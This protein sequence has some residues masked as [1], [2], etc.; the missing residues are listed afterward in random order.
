MLAI[1]RALMGRPKLLLLDEPSLGLSPLLVQ[2]IF[3]HH[4]PH[5]SR[6]RASPSCWSSRTPTSRC[7]PPT[8]AMCWRSGAS[9]LADHCATLMQTR[10]HQGILP[11][12]EGNRASAASGD[13]KGSGC[14]TE[15]HIPALLAERVAAHGSRNDPAQEGPRHLEGHRPGR[16]LAPRVR[17]IG[18]GLTAIGFRSRRRRLRD[19]GDAARNGSYVDLG[20]LGAGGVSGGIHPERG[21]ASRSARR[22]A[23]RDAACCSSRTRSSSTR[24]SG[25]RAAARRCDA[26]VI[27]D[28]KGL[29]DF[30]DPMCE[31]LADRSSHAPPDDRRLGSAIAADRRRISQPCCCCRAHGAS[32]T[33]THGDVTA[34]D[35]QCARRCW[36]CAPATSVW[37]CCRC[38]M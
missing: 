3:E 31:S 26:I 22:C 9:S 28:M 1:S 29:R 38:A 35:R 34:P 12:P 21:S 27:I 11:R 10:R 30:A 2:Q 5:Q 17:E 7:R 14:G 8:S 4:P 16:S 23:M 19:R 6:S 24:C 15:R 13:G 25:A 32:R 36:R 20:I 18:Q 33:L 37:R